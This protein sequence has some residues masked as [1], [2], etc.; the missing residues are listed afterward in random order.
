MKW[1]PYPYDEAHDG[2]DHGFISKTV[3]GDFIVDYSPWISRE[4]PWVVYWW[5]V[6]ADR[7]VGV[8]RL[9][10]SAAGMGAAEAYVKDIAERLIA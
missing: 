4:R 7:E 6:N 8:G 1:E 3:I 5:P 2:V 9:E 10:A